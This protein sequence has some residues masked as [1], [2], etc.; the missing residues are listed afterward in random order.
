MGCHSRRQ[1]RLVGRVCL[2]FPLLAACGEA[3]VPAD[4]ATQ[5]TAPLWPLGFYFL[6]AHAVA[7]GMIAV[8]YLLGQRHKGRETDE[9]YESGVASTGSARLRFS[10]HFYLVA[11]L[12]VIFD[13]E[14][15][16]LFAW[17]IAFLEVGWPGYVGVLVFIAVLAVALL[18]EWR[19]GALDWGRRG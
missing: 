4:A 10:A 3:A 16:F 9:P 17:A 14:A 12:F 1:L 18:Y 7:I 5:T 6:A 19:A 11:I 15:V 13:I 2:L 8:S